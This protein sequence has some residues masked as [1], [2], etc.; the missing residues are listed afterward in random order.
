[1]TTHKTVS[2]ILLDSP[3]IH[4][5][6]VMDISGKILDYKLDRDSVLEKYGDCKYSHGYSDGN[7]ELSIWIIQKSV[8]SSS[9]V[10]EVLGV[11]I[12][13]DGNIYIYTQP[14]GQ[15]RMEFAT[16]D[17]ADKYIR[18]NRDSIKCSKNFRKFR[19]EPGKGITASSLWDEPQ[20]SDDI[21]EYIDQRVDDIVCDVNDADWQHRYVGDRFRSRCKSILL[22]ELMKRFGKSAA[23]DDKVL[24]YIDESFS[25]YGED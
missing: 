13:D 23:S 22:K 5:V 17:E 25:G 20:Y 4:T 16:V 15:G 14:K 6:S 7:G 12:F 19:A 11:P 21:F 24:R 1:M 2:D 10:D 8:T 18:N 9:R 3:K